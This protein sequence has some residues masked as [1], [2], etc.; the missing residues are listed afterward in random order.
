MSGSTSYTE[1]QAAAICDWIA[2]G[3]SLVSYCKRKGTPNYRTVTRWLKEQPAFQADYRLAHEHQAAYLAEEILDLSDKQRLTKVSSKYSGGEVVV[4]T[5][6]NVERTRLQIDARK[7]YAAKLA[8][9]KY[10]DKL[11]LGGVVGVAQAPTELS[12]ED[13]VAIM[14]GRKV[15]RPTDDPD[16]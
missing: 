10:G 7:W 9:K 14:N 6:D 5:K 15:Q 3:R 1:E 2:G 8:P 16:A 13:L 11:E 4:V 12:D